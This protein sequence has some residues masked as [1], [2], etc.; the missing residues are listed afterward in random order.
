MTAELIT[1]LLLGALAGGFINGLSGTGTALFALGF[2][3]V[4]LDPVTAVAI[5]SLMSVVAGFQGLWVVRTAIFDNP[6]RLL[7]FVLPGLVGV[8]VG[9]WLLAGLDATI[10]RY[11]VA[12]F[13]IIYGAYFSFRAVLPAF[14]RPTPVVDSCVGGLGGVLGGATGMSGALPSIWMSLRPWTKF[15]TR[16]VLQPFNMVM[17][18]TTIGL[19]FSQGAYDAD[20]VRAILITVPT[21]LVAAQVGIAVFKRLTNTGFRRLLIGLNFVMGI[22]ILISE[23][24]KVG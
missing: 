9:V 24:T 4:V 20:A 8:P 16:A 7:R 5:V 21:G 3:L 19:L 13:L 12:A 14:E 23:L 10:L 2:Y 6:K 11:G 18:M 1:F 17:L 15:E 22:G